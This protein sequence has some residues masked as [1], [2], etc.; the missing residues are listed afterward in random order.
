MAAVVTYLPSQ[1]GFAPP[2]TTQR[3]IAP[4]A[5]PVPAAAAQQLLPVPAPVPAGQPLAPALR[6]TQVLPVQ[7][8]SSFARLPAFN[9]HNG[10]H[11]QE[12]I[13]R[14]SALLKHRSSLKEDT[15]SIFHQVVAGRPGLDVNG[16]TA[17]RQQLSAKLGV[18]CEALGNHEED[19]IRFDFDGDGLIEEHECRRLVR[20]RLRAY[21]E[22]LNPALFELDIPFET[23]ETKGLAMVK[24]LGA[25][26][27]GTVSLMKDGSGREVCVKRIGKGK[28]TA[29]GL[30]ELKTEFEVMRDL[31]NTRIAT[32]FGIFQ[33]PQ[34]IYFLNEPY[35]GGD[36]IGLEARARRAGAFAG[37]E[38]DLVRWWRRLFR[39]CVEGLAYLHRH[40]LM[41]CD[42]KEN[43]VMIKTT[44]LAEPEV[45]LIDYGLSREFT[46]T[47]QNLTGTPGYIP[48][49]TWQTKKWYPRGDVFSLG[50]MMLQIFSDVIPGEGSP[51]TFPIFQKGGS[52]LDEWARIAI[53]RPVPFQ[54]VRPA[55][56]VALPLLAIMLEKERPKRPTAPQ[57]LAH[58]W[59]AEAA[60]SSTSGEV[61]KPNLRVSRKKHGGCW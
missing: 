43:N 25:G 36:F 33:D 41:H 14:V 21:L 7:M 12:Q 16:L 46:S 56:K 9:S 53:T 32:T 54:L 59:L 34:Y 3:V 60:S 37:G 29:S 18:P 17:V 35:S 42:I 48:P 15:R 49:E 28:L 38:E 26:S 40:A 2:L 50:V 1:A 20:C 52:N 55:F 45:V 27:F 19:F 8:V 57:V 31:A 61:T 51:P 10:L 23:L 24:P 6:T 5:A 47:K 11:I 44:D 58:G 30:E 22:S 13:K 39:Q 4:V